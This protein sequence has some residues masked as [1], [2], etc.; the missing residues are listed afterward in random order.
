MIRMMTCSHSR[1]GV[2]S[3]LSIAMIS[4]AV[5]LM[6]TTTLATADTC[7]NVYSSVQ[8]KSFYLAV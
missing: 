5:L 3:L 2:V 8:A 4:V 6:V 7:E 1:R